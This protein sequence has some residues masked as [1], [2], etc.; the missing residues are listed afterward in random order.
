M[1]DHHL[2]CVFVHIN[3][4]GGIS[5]EKAL[6]F[7][8]QMHPSLQEQQ[9]LFLQTRTLEQWQSYFKFS[10]VRNPWDRLVSLYTFRRGKTPPQTL[11]PFSQWIRRVWEQELDHKAGGGRFLHWNQLDWLSV[12][13]RLDMDFIGR[14][15]N[16]A[17]DF[18]TVCTRLGI[19][20]PGLGRYNT[21]QHRPYGSYYDAETRDLV[22][23]KYE[24]DIEYFEYVFVADC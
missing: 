5:V 13:G 15:E 17:A 1:I 21:T 22:A 14:V 3:K 16:M 11:L 9:Q 4:C 18:A 24:R 10:F 19:D 20:N 23:R 12:D 6:G 8:V 2:Q 7:D